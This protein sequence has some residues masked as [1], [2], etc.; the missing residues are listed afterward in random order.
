MQDKDSLYVR[1]VS[2]CTLT[3]NDT[4]SN[5]L[6]LVN[7]KNVVSTGL[8][9]IYGSLRKII[10]CSEIYD[11]IFFESTVDSVFLD[12]VINI[13]KSLQIIGNM[14]P[15]P[16]VTHS[17]SSSL[18]SFDFLW[19]IEKNKY[20][21]IRDLELFAGNPNFP[22]IYNS[23]TLTLYN[24]LLKNSTN[25]VLSTTYANTIIDGVVEIR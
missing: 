2:L 7:Q 12:D 3:G 14:N 17:N 24:V 5:E 25:S 8:D 10:E 20:L 11:T 22:L 19:N 6:L 16:V 15:K 1:Q 4:S 23:G 9:N 18:P 21:Y 13:D